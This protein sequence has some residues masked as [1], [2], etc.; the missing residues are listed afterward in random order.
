METSREEVR[1]LSY[2]LFFAVFKKEK[3]RTSEKKG[4]GKPRLFPSNFIQEEELL[5]NTILKRGVVK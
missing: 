4:R 1:G 2:P 3:K 5:Y